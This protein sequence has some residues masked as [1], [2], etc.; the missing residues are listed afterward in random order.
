MVA[1]ATTSTVTSGGPT[2]QALASDL[3]DAL[4]YASIQKVRDVQISTR[5]R[6]AR[7]TRE[8]R[9]SFAS[10]CVGSCREEILVAQIVHE[11]GMSGRPAQLGLGLDARRGQVEVDQRAEKSEVLG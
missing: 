4:I 7:F 1:M 11:V 8:I 10:W 5:P 6:R 3:R 9:W 2:Q